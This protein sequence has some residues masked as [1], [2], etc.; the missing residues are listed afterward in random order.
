MMHRTAS[1]ALALALCACGAWPDLPEAAER[2]STGGWPRLQP[3][4]ELIGDTAPGSASD[5]AALEL[6]ARADALRRRAEL[7]RAPVPDADAFEALRLRIG[8]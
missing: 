8:G 6:T 7:L 1:L 3:L 5:E 4:D 2:T